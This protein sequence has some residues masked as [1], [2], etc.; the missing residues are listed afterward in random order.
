MKNLFLLPRVYIGFGILI[1]LFILSF[2]F[3]VLFTITWGLAG[4]GFMLLLT[5]YLVLFR[6]KDK[7]IAQRYLPEK[8]SNGDDNPI[9][10]Q[11][12]NNYNFSVNCQIID[13][14]PFQFQ[15]RDFLLEQPLQIAQTKRLTYVVSPK[16]RGEYHF[17][18]LNVYVNSPLQLV[19]KRYIFSE[20]QMLPCYPSFIQMRKYDLIAFA[21]NKYAFGLK[22]L[23]KIGNTTEFEQI[24]EY[25]S[26]DDIRTINWKATAKKN[27]L[28]VNQFLDENTETVYSIIDKG[29]LMQM[30]FEG[31]SLLNYA[32][33]STLAISNVV[34]KKNDRAGMLSFSKKVENIVAASNKRTHLQKIISSLY[35]LETNFSESDFGHLY[36][37]VKQSITHR[38]LL[39]LYTNFESLSS[40]ERQLPYLRAMAKSHVL[41]VIFFENTEL[42]ALTEKKIKN[43]DEIIDKIVAEKFNFEKRL[44]ANELTK[45]GIQ[46]ILTTPQNLSIE[47]INMYLKIK[48]KGF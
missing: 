23:R 32:I 8:L 35:N 10:I 14:I 25:V 30:P 5:D 18:K 13:E 17:G 22:K 47:T 28:M 24:K 39:L 20:G 4:V 1:V 15:Q 19:A 29:R 3:P 21:K 45:Y 2:L 42:K 6:G 12:T 48:A 7:L 37:A 44:I 46:S 31:M 9:E 27:E 16:F 26:G 43:T 36:S 40:L 33:N 11:L 34:L 38:S 41:V